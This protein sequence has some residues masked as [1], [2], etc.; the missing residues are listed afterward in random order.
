MRMGKLWIVN[1]LAEVFLL[2]SLL[3][4]ILL[5]IYRFIHPLR[6]TK[7]KGENGNVKGFIHPLRL[8]K[9]K[10]ENGN[11]K[12]FIHPLRFARPPVS[13]GQRG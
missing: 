11:V 3:P 12:G 9:V 4:S 2:V 10:G 5:S 7:V 8:T 13:V 6:L 1:W